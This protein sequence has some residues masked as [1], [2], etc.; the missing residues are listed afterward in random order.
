MNNQEKEELQE[1]IK[2]KMDEVYN[3]G[4]KTGWAAYAISAIEHIKSMHSVKEVKAY[5]KAEAEKMK[6][7]MNLSETMT[8]NNV[9]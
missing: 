8:N 7:E 5:F 3:L 2:T 9:E 1:T 4:I 6:K